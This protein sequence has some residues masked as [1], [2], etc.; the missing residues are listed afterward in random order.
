V[1]AEEMLVEMDAALK[2][3]KDTACWAE[4][5]SHLKTAKVLH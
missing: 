2:E 5:K 1:F 3:M 4:I